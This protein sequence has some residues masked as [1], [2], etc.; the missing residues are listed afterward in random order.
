MVQR[1]KELYNIKYYYTS[2][3][4]LIPVSLDQIYTNIFSRLLGHTFKLVRMKNTILDSIKLKSSSTY[5]LNKLTK[6][7]KQNNRPK[8]LESIINKFTWLEYNDR[9]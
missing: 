5:L 2:F 3:E 8:C 9:N 4:S 1:E 6:C 7:V